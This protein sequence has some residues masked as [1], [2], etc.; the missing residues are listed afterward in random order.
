MGIDQAGQ[1]GGAR[2]VDH[3]RPEGAQPD[4]SVLD[5]DGA[6]RGEPVAVEDPDVGERDLPGDVGGVFLRVG[7]GGAGERRKGRGRS[8]L[9][10]LS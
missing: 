5:D 1:Q 4:Q 6:R 3:S 8:W 9:P 10:R 7:D 2:A